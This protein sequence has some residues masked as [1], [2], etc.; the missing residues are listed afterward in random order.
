MNSSKQDKVPIP[1]PNKELPYAT[2]S[3]EPDRGVLR[4]F[5]DPAS[6]KI[7][8]L[9]PG[10]PDEHET[11]QP[12][13]KALSDTGVLA[14]VM[15]LPGFD[16]RPSDNVLWTEHKADGYT[17]WDMIRTVQA[18]AKALREESETARN[19]D[20]EQEPAQFTGIFHDWGVVPGT[21]WAG[22]VEKDPDSRGLDRIVFFDVLVGPPSEKEA[23]L[24]GS[25]VGSLSFKGTI[26]TVWYKV[27]FALAFVLQR[28]ISKHL[29]LCV[30]ISNVIVL[31]V[32]CLGPCYPFDT[33]SR[34]ALDI[35]P[36]GNSLFRLMYTAY[37][38]WFLVK[39]I[40]TSGG[41]SDDD[42]KMHKNWKA[43][44]ILYLYGPEKRTQFHSFET[45]ALLQKEEA[46][47]TSLS[48]AVEV[49]GTG[50]YLFLQ[51]QETCLRHVVDFMTAE[52]TFVEGRK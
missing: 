28:Y 33:A 17:F 47:G 15:C 7:A 42:T 31:E 8:L 3:S 49:E 37:P 36:E 19:K 1:K 11:F 46:E 18:A 14:G 34:E 4:L 32:C 20:G 29:A 23:E 41:V 10:F 6:S 50:H 24:A 38:Y 13:A 51:K 16:H 21:F 9:C 40:F 30:L 39:K 26:V 43:T 25:T 44:P 35:D 27:V 2:S 45:L 5:G 12:F 22:M 48:K 52:N